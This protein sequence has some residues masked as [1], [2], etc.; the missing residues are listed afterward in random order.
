MRVRACICLL[1]VRVSEY[2]RAYVGAFSSVRVYASLNTRVYVY[3]VVSRVRIHACACT[4]VCVYVHV[5]NYARACVYVY[6]VN[7]HVCV[8]VCDVWC[9]ASR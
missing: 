7:T 8:R 5:C 1:C 9:M 3:A 6:Y 4:C 2:T